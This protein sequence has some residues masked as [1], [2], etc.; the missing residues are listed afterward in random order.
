[1]ILANLHS[2]KKPLVGGFD[3]GLNKIFSRTRL[4]GDR[5]AA[6]VIYDHVPDTLM[7]RISSAHR[8]HP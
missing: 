6:E 8:T 5:S 2:I 3:P 1:M 7:D 4:D